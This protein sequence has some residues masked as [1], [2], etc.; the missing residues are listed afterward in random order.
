MAVTSIP[1]PNT[2]T[3]WGHFDKSFSLMNNTVDSNVPLSITSSASETL[4]IS[5]ATLFINSDAAG[6]P[7][8]ALVL[9]SRVV[10]PWMALAFSFPMWD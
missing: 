2:I 5:L 3:T 9:L 1:L 4:Q 6:G 10:W 8:V 7:K